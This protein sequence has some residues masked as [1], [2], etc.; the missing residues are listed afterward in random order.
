MPS[1][2]FRSSSTQRMKGHSEEV[3]GVG[4][5]LMAGLAE[6]C[7][8]RDAGLLCGDDGSWMDDDILYAY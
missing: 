4:S 8:M 6:L 3:P 1:S 7:V 5:F 2:A